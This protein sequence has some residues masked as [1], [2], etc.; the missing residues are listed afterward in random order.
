[1]VEQAM[2]FK[3]LFRNN[4]LIAP[5]EISNAINAFGASYAKTVRR[6][7]LATD[8]GEVDKTLFIKNVA[9]ILNNFKMTRKGPFQGIGFDSEGKIKGPVGKLEE[10]WDAV[11]SEV[12]AIKLQITQLRLAPRS[13]TIA[14][15]S[16]S[17]IEI[18]TDLIWSACKGLL[19][20]TMSTYSYGLVAASKIL[21]AVFPEIVVPIDNVQ[22]KQVFQTVD[23]GDV[24]K[25]MRSE[26]AEWEAI[27]GINID[28][29]EK[30]S[31]PTTLPAIYN[32]MAMEAR[33]Y[34]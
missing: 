20:I 16:D 27:T 33:D 32:V 29:C 31:V 22:W 30:E 3:I 34:I 7:I 26:I 12:V 24:I 9:R 4:Q 10:C 13:R 28:S 23:L 11:R 14:L 1:M 15:L 5:E 21:Y 6:T 8:K 17:Q 2:K 19:P 25:L 18:V